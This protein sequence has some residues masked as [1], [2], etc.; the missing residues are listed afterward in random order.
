MFLLCYKCAVACRG[1]SGHVVVHDTNKA[2]FLACRI[3]VTVLG[4]WTSAAVR[5][6]GNLCVKMACQSTYRNMNL[7][8]QAR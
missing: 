8:Q 6:Q 5:H 4:C 7:G 3:L 1:V 2:S